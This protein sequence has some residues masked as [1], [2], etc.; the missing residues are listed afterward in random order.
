[1]KQWGCW[2]TPRKAGYVVQVRRY[3][4]IGHFKMELDWIEDRGSQGC[5]YDLATSD[6]HCAGC[7]KHTKLKEMENV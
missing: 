6:P 5:G 2:N 1:V 4:S 3:D 7:A